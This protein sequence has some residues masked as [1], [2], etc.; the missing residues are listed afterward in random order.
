MNDS[1]DIKAAIVRSEGKIGARPEVGRLTK[2]S[3][4]SIRSGL[5]C[6]IQDGPWKLTADM[7][8]SLGGRNTGPDPGVFGRAAISSCLAIGYATWFARMDVAVNTIDVEV[9]ADFDYGGVLGVSDAAASYSEFRYSVTVDS[10]AA[11]KEI[12][13]VLDRADAH[14]PWLSNIKTAFDPRRSVQITS[15]AEEN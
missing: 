14:S 11:E 13:K 1:G 7:R 3:R 10:P 15:G 9:S 8:E 4:A 2:T 6:D 5:T 12:I